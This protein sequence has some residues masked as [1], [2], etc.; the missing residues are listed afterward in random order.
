MPVICRAIGTRTLIAFDYDGHHRIAEPYRHGTGS[1]G[2]EL[3]VGY[4]VAGSSASADL[5]WRLFDV[6]RITELR[7]VNEHFV[8]RPEYDAEDPRIDSVHCCI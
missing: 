3:L 1:R 8:C 4:Q 5:G 6:S 2:R 7:A